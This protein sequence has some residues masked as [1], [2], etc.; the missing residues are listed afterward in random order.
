M[1]W[2]NLP[3]RKKMAVYT[4]AALLILFVMAGLGIFLTEKGKS[5]ASLALEKSFSA[6]S[7]SQR[8]IDHMNWTASLNMF[9]HGE[10]DGEGI[11][12]DG[13]KCILGQWYYG[14][15]RKRVE[16]IMPEL[17]PLLEKLEKP[18]L[19][20]HRGAGRVK[21]LMAQDKKLEAVTFMNETIISNSR[22]VIGL[23]AQLGKKAHELA[24]EDRDMFM[25]AGKMS[26]VLSLI[27]AL[28]FTVVGAVG[29]Y[30]FARNLSAPLAQ[31]ADMG[32]KVRSG[33]LD[34]HLDIH[35]KDEIGVIADNLNAMLDSL[36]V[37]LGFSRGVLAGISAPLAVCNKDGS[38]KMINQRFAAL[39]GRAG[40]GEEDYH[41]MNYAEF[42]F[43]EG[44]LR[45][46]MNEVLDSRAE[47]TDKTLTF[48]NRMGERRHVMA[49]FSPLAS[50]DG[51]LMGA[52]TI[53]SDLSESYAQQER[54]ATL[55]E[56]INQSAR[57]AQGIS[58]A[59]S[60]GFAEITEVLKE[61]SDA[62]RRQSET[63]FN[64]LRGIENMTQSMDDIARK[65]E[66]ARES[67]ETTRSEAAN[68]AD[69]VRTVID[70]IERV[71]RQT[72]E[73]AQDIS[74]LSSHAQDISKVIILIEDIADQTNLL[75]LNAAI[76]AARAGEAGRGFAVVADEVRKLA[77]KTMTAT[78][79]VVTAVRSIQDS[80]RKSEETTAAAVNLTQE[81]TALAEKSG[82]SLAKI[83]EM[84]DTVA[85]EISN[86]AQITRE[87]SQVS[88]Q[89]RDIMNEIGALS[90][91]TVESMN[92]SN[93]G[94]VVLARQ[95]GELKAL[96]EDMRNERR[97][98]Q[99]FLI[100]RPTSFQLSVGGKSCEAALLDISRAGVRLRLQGIDDIRPGAQVALDNFGGPL[101][102]VLG[103]KNA[104][105]SWCDGKQVGIEFK[106]P[107][108]LGDDE[109]KKLALN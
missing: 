7:F 4:C 31:I 60:V 97:A 86:I 85:N 79:D 105:V 32:M 74:A 87:Q 103:G 24:I 58:Q 49:S 5:T 2:S 78:R 51:D 99:R 25:Q 77:E 101:G 64:A 22:E 43:G 107:L 16:V 48:T 62:A 38:M 13:H 35:R 17:A 75:A 81:S 109:L 8:E 73:L 61:S 94:V 63:S 52:I 53:M 45:T 37:E 47:I 6:T 28:V 106:K 88:L 55:N 44:K 15:E 27:I 30:F 42:C 108:E 10:S 56:T 68:G 40:I 104:S 18:H 83:V 23:L 89:V 90:Q 65:A 69:I 67:T 26:Q 33:K 46:E 39:W 3:I 57:N 71:S 12:E 102:R 59:Q 20:L 19:E 54:I 95:S 91:R 14:E 9:I 50:L 1:S 93:D 29:S 92:R 82:K 34:A 70:G 80:T 21:E 41:K 66:Q 36:K 11:Q 96:I 76:E 100:S 84:A 98:T 72:G